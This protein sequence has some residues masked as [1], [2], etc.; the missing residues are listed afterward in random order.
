MPDGKR[1]KVARQLKY[2]SSGL[3]PAA[4]GRPDPGPDDDTGDDGGVGVREPRRPLPPS[5]LSGAGARPLPEPT[6][7][8]EL[9]NP[10]VR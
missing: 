1:R 7:A 2:R 10:P 8:A 3:P 5:P 9:P 6:I 4:D